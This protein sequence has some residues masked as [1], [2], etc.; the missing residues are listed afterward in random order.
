MKCYNLE[1]LFATESTALRQV[2]FCVTAIFFCP[3]DNA[4]GMVN[5]TFAL[6]AEGLPDFIQLEL[7]MFRMTAL[8][9]VERNKAQLVSELFKLLKLSSQ[10]SRSSSTPHAASGKGSQQQKQTLA[11]T[12][13]DDPEIPRFNP[14]LVKQRGGEAH[15]A[16]TSDI[17]TDGRPRR[18]LS[19]MPSGETS[20]GMSDD[21]GMSNFEA[22][23]AVPDSRLR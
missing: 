14:L 2:M 9:V 16:R 18:T 10:T 11:D 1:F 6:C 4:C 20:G 21:D 17:Q 15:S 3:T 8:F 22:P 13:E 5:Q 7:D 12:D 23:S 19:S